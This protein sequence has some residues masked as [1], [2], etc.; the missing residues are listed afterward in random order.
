MKS[1]IS[2]QV[3]VHL[4]TLPDN[5]LSLPQCCR[6]RKPR[7]WLTRFVGSGSTGNVWQ[8]H[9][10]NS[11]NLFATKFVELRRRSDA[12]SCQ[13]LRNEFKVYLSLEEAYQSGK[14]P[15][16]IAPQCYGAFEG[17]T[18]DVLILELCDGTLSKWDELNDEE[19]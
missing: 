18:V 1:P 15:Y 17:D 6:S 8:C 5:T 3:W 14:L 12:A 11:D 2:S 9:L 16:R 7:L 4:S 10:D 13:R 19:R